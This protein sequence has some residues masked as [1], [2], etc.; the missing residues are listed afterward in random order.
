[1]LQRS[2]SKERRSV[3]GP[4]YMTDQQMA[5]YLND[6]RTNH[7]DRPTGA[8]PPPST[9]RSVR[10]SM[11]N[12]EMSAPSRTPSHNS[13]QEMIDD[14]ADSG[15]P[16]LYSS[17][18]HRKTTSMSSRS[19]LGR[20]LV[21]PPPKV[22]DQEE[23]SAYQEICGSRWVE[24]QEARS[25]RMALEEMDMKDERGEEEKIFEAA[26]KEASELVWK[27]QNGETIPF[28]NPDLDVENTESGAVT[29]PENKYTAHLEKG[30][31]ARSLSR[32]SRESLVLKKRRSAT[33]RS[34]SGSSSG[35]GGS[36]RVVSDGSTK[37]LDSIKEGS[38]GDIRKRSVQFQIPQEVNKQENSNSSMSPK[39]AETTVEERQAPKPSGVLNSVHFR[40]PFARARNSR[41][42]LGSLSR[43]SSCPPQDTRRLEKVEIQRNPPSQSRNPQYTTYHNASPAS[44]NLSEDPQDGQTKMK[45]GKEIRSDDIRKATSMSLKDRSPKLP[46]PSM[47]SDSPGRPIVSFDKE[48]KPKE[49]SV[50]QQQSTPVAGPR[51]A[52]KPYR[53]LFERES[54]RNS[55]PESKPSFSVYQDQS[56]HRAS[57]AETQ[58]GTPFR[59]NRGSSIDSFTKPTANET[60]LVPNLAITNSTNNSS[61]TTKPPFPTIS[62]L[63]D[64]PVQSPPAIIK[65]PIPTMSF[66]DDSQIAKRPPIPTINLPDDI[67][68]QSQRSCMP[69]IP[70]INLPDDSSNSQPRSIPSISID[71]PSINVSDNSTPPQASSTRPLPKP[72]SKAR[73]FRAQPPPQHVAGRSTTVLCQSC[74]FP[75]SGRIVTAAGVRFHPGCFRCYHCSEA[76][77]CVAFY[78]EPESVLADRVERIQKRQRGEAVDGPSEE[79]DGD[80]GMR[81]YCHL[82]FH[83]FFS[84]RCKSCKTPIE[85]DVIVACGAEWHAGH[86]FC[87]QCGDVS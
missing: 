81:F 85:G 33:S 5:S 51:G 45:E 82:D 67:P 47:V 55:L 22:E 14:P 19:F 28:R 78:P 32:S 87:A 66:P 61:T 58:T 24:K 68:A 54:G 72:I 73:H 75:I 4:V 63:D 29:E 71:V 56:D 70:T 16:H 49:I 60:Q 31:H 21:R 25:L 17:I 18:A 83:E 65:P 30:S 27:H 41:T 74:A 39:E 3:G 20:P 35:S 76:L 12:L 15:S 59:T 11:S 37:S 10:H 86:F 64:T 23:H 34:V 44:S 57:P 80:E 62:V 26:Q 7:P 43:P 6:L 38:E 77:E 42:S 52:P 79:E 50:E 2:K 69:P 46:T 1:M 36:G 84:P 53:S 13:S 40:N 48:W 8:R 9:F